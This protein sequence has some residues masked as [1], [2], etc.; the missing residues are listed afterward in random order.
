MRQSQPGA[1]H[2]GLASEPQ[3]LCGSKPPSLCYFVPEAG[4]NIL[5]QKKIVD[6]SSAAQL[7]ALPSAAE[8]WKRVEFLH[9]PEMPMDRSTGEP[10]KG[11]LRTTKPVGVETGI[12]SASRV[13]SYQIQL[14]NLAANFLV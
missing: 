11:L 14:P 5:S 4:V 6:P 10:L 2:R 8:L 1:P 12:M 3:E 13:D 9:R 7:S